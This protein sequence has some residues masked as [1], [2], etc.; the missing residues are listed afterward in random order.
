MAPH[1]SRELFDREDGYGEGYVPKN[2]KRKIK[3][4]NL[5]ELNIKVQTEQL[6]PNEAITETEVPSSTMVDLPVLDKP[7][8]AVKLP[9]VEQKTETKEVKTSKEVVWYEGILEDLKTITS[10]DDS[11]GEEG[12]KVRRET[13]TRLRNKGIRLPELSVDARDSRQFAARQQIQGAVEY[14]NPLFVG[15]YKREAIAYLNNLG[16]GNRDGVPFL[17]GSVED[18][19]RE[20][21]IEVGGVE[22][23]DSEPRRTQIQNYLLRLTETEEAAEKMYI[24]ASLEIKGVKIGKFLDSMEKIL[25]GRSKDLMRRLRAVV[26]VWRMDEKKKLEFPTMAKYAD[27]FA[28]ELGLQ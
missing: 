18:M 17:S 10:P 4:R 15:K 28:R 19:N 8:E 7:I 20:K 6:P 9:Q 21:V 5:D 2:K 27:D 14:L 22:K 1:G 25:P 24:I 23:D 13:A 16:I 11:F 3:E 12:W 26:E